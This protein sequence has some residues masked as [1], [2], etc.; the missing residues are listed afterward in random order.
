[1]T[2][3]ITG[4]HNIYFSFS[5]DSK[6]TEVTFN[7]FEFVKNSLPVV[8]FDIDESE[9]TV[10][11]MNNSDNHTDM[12]HGSMNIDI[13]SGYEGEYS[14]S[15]ASATYKM[16]YI[17]G[18]GNSTWSESKKPYK[19]K[20]ESKADILGMGSNKHWVL[21]ANIYD[22]SKMRNKMTYTLGER[23][24]IAYT[25]KSVPVDVVMNGEYYGNYYL[26]A[27]GTIEYE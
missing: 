24:G 2:K 23:L 18:R 13:P 12:C 22:N 20:L 19:I 7:S 15:L 27:P 26:S 14:D 11:D 25:P 5:T 17:R 6:E 21:V 1:M 8:S 10:E 4:K 9:G 16:E 3:N